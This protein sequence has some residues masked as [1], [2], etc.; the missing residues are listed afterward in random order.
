MDHKNVLFDSDFT[1]YMNVPFIGSKK[2]VVQPRSLSAARAADDKIAC[3][4]A[5]PKLEYEFSPKYN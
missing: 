3:G 2:N 1:S 5:L 4:E